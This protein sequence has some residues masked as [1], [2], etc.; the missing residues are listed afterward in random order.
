MKKLIKELLQKIGEDPT[1]EGLCDT[2]RRVAAM[3]Q[4]LTEGYAKDPKSLA[5]TFSTERYDE[6]IIVKN[7]EFYSLCEHHLLP[8]FGHVT[9]GYIPGKQI[10]GLSKIPRLIEIYSRRLQNQERLTCQIADTL[11]DLLQSKGVG[12]IVSA[13]HLCMRMRGVQK[14][15]AEMTTSA[16]TGLFK[17]DPKTREEFLRLSGR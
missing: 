8:F 1:R 5:T 4:Q 13:T 6:M 12:V 10:I 15:N 7:I 16:L 9:V 2:P 17:K 3:W 14:E 11:N